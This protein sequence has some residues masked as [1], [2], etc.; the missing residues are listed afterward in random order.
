MSF[1]KKIFIVSILILV[2]VIL[3]AYP[4]QYLTEGAPKNLNFN[5]QIGRVDIGNPQICNFQVDRKTNKITLFPNT[6]GETS[7]LVYDN[8]GKQRDNITIVVSSKNLNRYIKELTKILSSV[9]GLKIYQVETKVVVEGEVFLSEDLATVDKV[10]KD[11]PF[12]VNLVKLSRN[13]QRII[14][15]KIENEID[16]AEVYVKPFKD[17][18]ILDG[19]VYQQD[20]EERAL[21]IAKLFWPPAKVQSIIEVRK[22][23]KPPERAKMIQVSVHY[24]VLNKAI[25]KNFLFKWAPFPETSANAFMNM[26]PQTGSTQFTGTLTAQFSSLIPRLNYMKSIGLVRNLENPML[27]VKSG[28]SANLFSGTEI[29]IPIA[30]ANGTASMGSK[31]VGMTLSVTP[32][33]YKDD[34]DLNITVNASSLGKPTAKGDVTMDTNNLTT[35]QFVRNGESVVIGGIIRTSRT[36]SK[37]RQ[38]DSDKP[39]EAVGMFNLFKTLDTNVA[40][41]QFLIFVTPKILEY[42][43]EAN[44]DLKDYFNLYEV[45]PTG[46]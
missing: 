33:V 20:Q 45:Y 23:S 8:A 42:A 35:H 44:K 15:K 7:V 28:K 30:Q 5:F 17:M 3:N 19:K 29:M 10:V 38:P 27:S 13:A 43:G 34:I 12:V 16:L 39:D 37:D 26:N 32:T 21:K 18:M 31:N 36:Y 14:A 46:Q 11:V 41:Q 22:E 40:R 9:E 6:A 1:F 2:P 4:T 24:V 25:D